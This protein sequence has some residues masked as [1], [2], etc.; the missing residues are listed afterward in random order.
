MLI[1]LTNNTNRIPAFMSQQ[2][3]A[4]LRSRGFMG[5]R[6]LGDYYGMNGNDASS[7]DPG[8]IT[9]INAEALYLLN[10]VRANEGKAP[11]PA[12]QYAPTVNVGV[13]D[14]AKTLLLI[15]AGF[16]ALRALR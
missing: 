10:L 13:S 4:F 2:P 1:D 9:A 12:Q 3:Q 11:L 6:G 15:G 5:M 16:L 8:I 14:G 7:F